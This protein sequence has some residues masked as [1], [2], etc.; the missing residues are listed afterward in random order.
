MTVRVF[1]RV[2]AGLEEIA[3]LDIQQTDIQASS[4]HFAKRLI[5]FDVVGD[6]TPLITL[7]SVDDL[8]LHVAA[9][10]GIRHTQD[11]LANLRRYVGEMDFRSAAEQISTVRPLAEPVTFYVTVSRTGKHNYSS[12]EIAEVFAKTIQETTGWPSVDDFRAASINVRVLLDGSSLLIGLSLNSYSLHRRTYK[13]CHLPGSLKPPVAYLM[14]RI[15]GCGS[16]ADEVIIDPMCGVGTIPIEAHLSGDSSQVFG[17][18]LSFSAVQ[19]AAQNWQAAFAGEPVPFFRADVEHYPLR[20][21]IASKIISNPP[22]GKQLQTKSVSR[23]YFRFLQTALQI[24]CEDMIC[25]LLTDH[26]QELLDA[27]SQLSSF[28]LLWVRQISLY[29][30]YPAICVLG[31]PGWIGR[32][33][34]AFSRISPIGAGIDGLIDTCG[35]W[36]NYS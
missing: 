13:H 22:W 24:G 11:E 3:W 8:Y 30:S 12:V 15:A 31:G 35:I 5:A 34:K 28:E 2:T 21:R 18:D 32:G 7:K 27:M 20:G 10:E 23:L 4:P 36:Q 25:V 17:S 26:V 19:C 9:I 16:G 14:T 33:K 29:G 6:L 1:C